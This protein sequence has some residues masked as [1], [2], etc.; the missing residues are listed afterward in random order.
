[1]AMTSGRGGGGG[2]GSYS[3]TV[4]KSYTL[5]EAID[6]VILG[7]LNADDVYRQMPHPLKQELD[8]L[9]EFKF[10]SGF[11]P[12]PVPQRQ[13]VM[14]SLKEEIEKAQSQPEK[15]TSIREAFE[16]A[17]NGTLD[18]LE[19]Y[20]ALT[21]EIRAALDGLA[22]AHNLANFCAGSP[23]IRKEILGFVVDMFRN[24]KDNAEKKPET[25]S[26]LQEAKQ[27]AEAEAKW[28][29]ETE[30]KQRAEVEAKRRAEAE[31]KRRAEQEV[32]RR[33][34][35]ESERR[36]AKKCILCGEG[37][38]FINRLFGRERHPECTMWK[39]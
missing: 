27:R 33:Q 20:Q 1:M 6:K 14:R 32:K 9:A 21:D 37:L 4:T 35:L 39:G 15:S 24:G 8:R 29:A 12:L 11:L 26:G 38:G 36:T 19:L 31:A 10:S 30:A 23:Q 22:S 17:I 3:Y 2:G 28:R 5:A 34:M 16:M 25:E 13:E 18:D 7:S